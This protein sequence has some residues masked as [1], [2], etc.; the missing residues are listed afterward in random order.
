VWLADSP[1]PLS[2]ISVVPAGPPAQFH[3]DGVDYRIAR[4]WGPERIETGWWRT[5]GGWG[6]GAR[7]SGGRTLARPSPQPPVPTLSARRDYYRVE[8]TSGRRF[9]LFRGLADAR[10][11]FHG[12]F[13]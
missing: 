13:G 1:L 10:W 6:L 2:V 8:T 12:E 11:F 3:F 9:W 7:G 5:G 4:S